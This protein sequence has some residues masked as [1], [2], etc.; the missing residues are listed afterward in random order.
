LTVSREELTP[1]SFLRRSALVYPDRVA[2][3]HGERRHTYRELGER[4]NRLASA[5][6]AAG[7]EHGDRVAFLCPNT[8]AQLEAHFGIPAAGGVLVA[9]NYRLS[10]REVAYILEHS[11]AR[12]VFADHELEHLLEEVGTDASLQVVR[13]DDT[14][15]PGD[16]YEDFLASGS[17]D[18]VEPV[19]VDEE[20]TIAIDYT[21]GTTGQPKGV[22]YSHRG[23]Y[24][25]ATSVALMTGLGPDSVFLW[26]LPMFHCNGWCFTWGVTAVGGRHVCL[27]RVEP[28]AVWDLLEREEVTHYNAA[29]TVQIAVVGHEQARPLEHGVLTT[30]GGAPPSPTLLA[31]LEELGIRTVHSYGLTET[32]GPATVCERQEGWDELP[33]EEQARL[34]GRQGVNHLAM[35][36]LRVADRSGAEVPWDGETL[37][38]ILL[39]GNT[40]MQGYYRDDE[41]TEAAFEGGWFHSGDLAVR[42]P[43]GYVEIRDRKKDVVVSGGENISTVEVEHAVALHPAVAE[44]AV[45]AVPDDR[46]GERPKAFVELSAGEQA[47]EDEILE[48]CRSELAGFKRP[49]AVELCELPKTSTGKVQK[50]LLR[51][52]E[53][54]GRERRVN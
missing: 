10:A 37:G 43:D 23:A 50:H 47:T 52:R 4:S 48:F 20:E 51:D 38:E 3:V 28:E 22:V 30:I 27:R 1:V 29:P 31:Q 13:L 40:V 6:R 39:R 7:L 26:T 45:V 8:P 53:W 33:A 12:F 49:A 19:L 11:G 35:P 2:V 32:Y 41:A 21:S 46:W 5:L 25:N 17:P 18:P 16:P 9:I 54:A 36:P 14:G 34:N 44:A 24:L 15:R 42:H